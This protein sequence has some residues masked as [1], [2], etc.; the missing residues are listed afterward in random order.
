MVEAEPCYEL[1]LTSK[2]SGNIAGNTL[3]SICPMPTAIFV[4]NVFHGSGCPSWIRT[5]P[6]SDSRAKGNQLYHTSVEAKTWHSCMFVASFPGVNVT[7]SVAKRPRLKNS[8]CRLPS[9]YYINKSVLT[10][11]HRAERAAPALT[12]NSSSKFSFFAPGTVAP[13]TCIPTNGHNR[14]DQ[15]KSPQAIAL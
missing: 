12:L 11:P 13:L 14:G 5:P 4:E 6:R 8:K 9:S 1:A 15:R 10:V 3:V 7:K 2:S